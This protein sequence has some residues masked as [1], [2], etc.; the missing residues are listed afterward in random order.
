MLAA[1][2]VKEDRMGRGRM[3]AI[4][5]LALLVACAIAPAAGPRTYVAECGN[6]ALRVKPATWSAGCTDAAPRAIELTWA[7][8]GTPRATGTG[9]VRGTPDAGVT[10]LFEASLTLTNVRRLPCAARPRQYTRAVLRWTVPPQSGSEEPGPRSRSYDIGRPCP[11]FVLGERDSLAYAG[12][13]VARPRSFSA[14]T[15][16]RYTELRWR[17]WGTSRATATGRIIPF[18][19]AA[20]AVSMTAYGLNNDFRCGVRPAYSRLRV[21]FAGGTPFI[22]TLCD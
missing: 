13:G 4:A 9:K 7:T 5:C 2:F 18:V 16:E 22:L 14:R 21:T 1:A 12:L 19:T 6:G 11:R 15:G 17:N 3:S 10:P 20:K 8:W